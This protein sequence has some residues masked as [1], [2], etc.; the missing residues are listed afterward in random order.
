MRY[1]HI[2][3]PVKPN[4]EDQCPQT[5]AR[6]RNRKADPAPDLRGDLLSGEEALRLLI[7]AGVQSGKFV[8]RSFK[9]C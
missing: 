5:T 4:W 7:M 1:L 8:S 2:A 3:G 6:D 9:A